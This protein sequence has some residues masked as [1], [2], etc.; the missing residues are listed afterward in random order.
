MIICQR[1]L[2]RD[3]LWRISG[4]ST[5][6]CSIHCEQDTLESSMDSLTTTLGRL[7]P[8]LVHLP[9]GMLLLAFILECLS[10]T[11]TYRKLKTGVQP[12]LFFGA[13]FAIAA[14]ISGL[15]LK[16]EGGYDEKLV[17]QHQYFGITT[18]VFAILL[19]FLRRKLKAFYIDPLR[20]RR[21]KVLL[22]FPLIVLLTATGHWGGSL[23]H[24]EAYL[25]EGIQDHD[26]DPM[27]RVRNIGNP[28]QA[29]LF[30][31]VIVPVL[32]AKC[33]SCHSSR[34][35]K[36]ELRLDGR[37]FV[38]KGGKNGEVIVTGIPDSSEL[39][40]RLILPLEDEHHMPPEEKPQLSS[41]EID[42]LKIWIAGGAHFSKQVSDFPASDKIVQLIHSLQ[43][44]SQPS[45][46]PAE[47]IKQADIETV[48][49][50]KL[51]GAVVIQTGRES[52]YLMVN[53]INATHIDKETFALIKN[54]RHHVVWLNAGNERIGD[55]ELQAFSQLQNL[56]ILYLNN[57]KV[58]D[59]GVGSLIA[60]K[61][62][63]Y[64]NLTNT[65]ITNESLNHLDT[66]KNLERLFLF[67]TQITQS[68]VKDFQ[69]RFQKVIIDTGHYKLEFLPGDT[70]VYKKKI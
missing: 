56:R 26:F 36:G 63:R 54:L 37:L 35:Q 49:K 62:L 18:T 11:K 41:T 21:A 34:K 46:I 31:D 12:A 48:N 70:I 45:W 7:H 14:C 15:L 22:F 23:T 69:D 58:T 2:I 42:I 3:N 27:L 43:Y 51:T 20:R 10:I 39:Y 53:L 28:D 33:F 68:G 65:S 16:E 4:R 52:N 29:I 66:L 5:N 47:R 25:F 50:L 13:V 6:T 32:E 44:T 19:F 17:T 57:S 61:E 64:L 60:L 9:I 8:L 1:F 40:K 38:E 67:Q 55:Q 30:E 59:D 24:G